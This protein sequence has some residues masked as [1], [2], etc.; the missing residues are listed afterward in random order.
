MLHRPGELQWLIKDHARDSC[1]GL[2]SLIMQSACAECLPLLQA[3]NRNI[4]APYVSTSQSAS[5]VTKAV[6]A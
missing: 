2:G 5:T 4:H 1:R 3:K 6:A